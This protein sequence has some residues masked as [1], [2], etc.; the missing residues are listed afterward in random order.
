MTESQLRE[1]LAVHYDAFEIVMWLMLPQVLLGG[2]TPRHVIDAGR[3][4]EVVSIVDRMD[5]VA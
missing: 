3:I 5:A 4:D 1:R 2:D